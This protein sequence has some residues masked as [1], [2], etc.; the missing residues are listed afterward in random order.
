MEEVPQPGVRCQ[1]RL[2]NPHII[3]EDGFLRDREGEVLFDL[4]GNPIEDGYMRD[5]YGNVLT[6]M[7]SR[8]PLRQIVKVRLDG[9]PVNHDQV[10]QEKGCTKIMDTSANN[11][12][13]WG[14]TR[15]AISF[16]RQRIDSIITL[17]SFF[18]ET[19]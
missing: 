19:T 13:I 3:H 17:M 18:W 6:D 7:N 10:L 14:K 12:V 15:M 11:L 1:P 9:T 5:T 16:M 8:R 2:P 4:N